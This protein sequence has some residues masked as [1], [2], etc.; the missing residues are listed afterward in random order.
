MNEEQLKYSL[1]LEIYNSQNTEPIPKL[2]INA[3]CLNLWWSWEYGHVL[4]CGFALM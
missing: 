2:T 3:E 1:Y 4:G